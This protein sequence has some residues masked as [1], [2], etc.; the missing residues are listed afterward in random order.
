MFFCQLLF[1]WWITITFPKSEP[2]LQFQCKLYF[3]VCFVHTDGI[4]HLC[5]GAGVDHLNQVL[6]L[7]WWQFC[8]IHW[9]L[10]F[11]LWKHCKKSIWIL[12]LLYF[13]FYLL[14]FLSW[15]TPLSTQYLHTKKLSVSL[16]FEK[17]P[18]ELSHSGAEPE[19]QCS[20]LRFF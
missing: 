4:L 5:Q 14:L 1:Q 12:F 11:S 18:V 13:L 10:F 9:E 19:I 16:Q 15:C 7:M 3:T 20:F 6:L 8:K 2:S 17:L